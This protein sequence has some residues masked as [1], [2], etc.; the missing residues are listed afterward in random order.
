M[1]VAALRVVAASDE[2]LSPAVALVPED[3]SGVPDAL[4]PARKVDTSGPGERARAA[5][6]A[7]RFIKGPLPLGWVAAAA[8]ANAVQLSP[9]TSSGILSPPVFL[10]RLPQANGLK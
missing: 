5:R 2:P 9:I 4:I 8:K 6:R 3:W 1:P 10:G 7:A